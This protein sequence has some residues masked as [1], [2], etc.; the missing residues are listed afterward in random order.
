MGHDVT[1]VQGSADNLKVTYPEDL[2]VAEA[3]LAMQDHHA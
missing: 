2:H 3:I 1:I